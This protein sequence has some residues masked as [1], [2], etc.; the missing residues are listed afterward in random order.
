MPESQAWAIA[1]QQS[2]ALGKSPKGYGTVKGRREAKAKYPTPKDDEE[3]ANPGQLRSEKTAGVLDFL[4][5]APAAAASKVAP[6]ASNVKAHGVLSQMQ[7]G[8][9]FGGAAVDPFL[10]ARQTAQGAAGSSGLKLAAWRDMLAKPAVMPWRGGL[11]GAGIGAAG[12]LLHGHM[13]KM[14]EGEE[15]SWKDYATPAAIGA[16]GG[17]ILGAGTEHGIRALLKPGVNNPE[18]KIDSVRGLLPRVIGPEEAARRGINVKPDKPN[19]IEGKYKV[20][21]KGPKVSPPKGGAAGEVMSGKSDDA[22]RRLSAEE[23]SKLIHN[24]LNGKA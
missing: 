18:S 5:G 12:G 17:G 14:P 16:L 3:M 6:L 7:K 20:V 4:K 13:K 24:I 8:R 10:K 2:H 11:G 23:V 9:N 19:I 22:G 21:D 1:T 15:K